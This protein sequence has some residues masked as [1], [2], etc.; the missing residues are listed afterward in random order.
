MRISRINLKL[1]FGLKQYYQWTFT[2]ISL[3]FVSLVIVEYLITIQPV[4][5]SINPNV[6]YQ[7]FVG[8]G[9]SLAWWAEEVGGWNSTLDKT[10]NDSTRQAVIKALFDNT[11]NPDEGLGFNVVRYNFGAHTPN[12]PVSCIQQIV[13]N[14]VKR[15]FR[16]IPSLQP[17]PG[18]NGFD[19]TLDPNQMWVLKQAQKH[20]ANLFE[21]FVNSAP[22]WMLINPCT[23][24]ALN[25]YTD[26]LDPFHY[27]NFVNYIATIT[28]HFHD[29]EGITFKTVEPFNEPTNFWSNIFA[30]Q[31]GMYVNLNT[32]KI[33]L[34]KLH[35]KFKENG[36]SVYTSLSADDNHSIQGTIIDYQ[37]YSINSSVQQYISQINT[38]SYFVCL[39]RIL[40]CN[41]RQD[42]YNLAKQHKKNIWQSEWGWPLGDGF[43]LGN[44]TLPSIIRPTEMQAA[45]ILSKQILLDEWGMHPTAWNVWQAYD[46]DDPTDSLNHLFGLVARDDNYNIVKPKRYYAMAQYSKFIRPGFQMV[47]INNAK[48]SLAAW[49]QSLEKLVIVTTN[50]YNG[51]IY[52]PFS[53]FIGG[54]KNFTY[55]LSNFQKIFGSVEIQPYRTS[56]TE[57]MVKQPCI[58]PNNN[59]F[60]YSASS[61]SITT[62]IISKAA[63]SG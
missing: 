47:N 20:G 32:Q 21:V 6:Q 39:P 5:V 9:T 31:E 19:F 52:W 60:T 43:S 16:I 3:F 48:N 14:S 56:E 23:G 55:D 30:S 53:K 18:T 10:P 7:T 50:F 41:A 25:G 24:G 45:L 15:R 11:F 57:N 13:G 59:H 17:F 54:T 29:V 46:T 37:G 63:C 8:W 36:V 51:T 26:N 38:H 49:N 12:N 61:G 2:I 22:V 28:K 33:I 58:T 35:N 62:F 44:I 4:S 27:D 34:Q 1:I 42:L 40:I